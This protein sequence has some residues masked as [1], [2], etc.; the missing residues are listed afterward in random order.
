MTTECESAAKPASRKGLGEKEEEGKAG[1][2]KEGK[3]EAAK[4]GGG[5]EG[6]AGRGAGEEDV[7]ADTLTCIICQEILHDC[8]R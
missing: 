2:G 7:F 5:G 8:I 3:E 6:A 1:G 4:S